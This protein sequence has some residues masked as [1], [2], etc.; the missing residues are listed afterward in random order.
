MSSREQAAKAFE[1]AKLLQEQK[2]HPVKPLEPAQAK[3]LA[4]KNHEKF[5]DAVSKQTGL[6]MQ[7][8]QEIYQSVVIDG[9][10]DYM[11]QISE[12]A[13]KS[14]FLP[15]FRET[16]T[17]PPSAEKKE[18]RKELLKAWIKIAGSTFT[19]VRVLDKQGKELFIVPAL[20]Q[21]NAFNPLRKDG[22]IPFAAIVELSKRMDDHSR[23]R[24]EDFQHKHL[25]QKLKEINDPKNKFKFLETQ[26]VWESIFERY[27]DT[28]TTAQVKQSQVPQDDDDLIFD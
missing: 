24:S 21:T 4:E 27:P 5:V 20:N 26:K 17:S 12:E 3:A 6:N 7:M 2:D 11:G 19:E 9:R 10:R 22:S 16:L 28:N 23:A 25:D 14:V 18:E 1:Q 15:F 13:F 8:M